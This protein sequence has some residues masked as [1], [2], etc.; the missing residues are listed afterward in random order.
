MADFLGGELSYRVIG[1][2]I[3]SPAITGSIVE[4]VIECAT[5]ALDPA[6]ATEQQSLPSFFIVGPPRT[7]S[8]WLYEI[9]ST[10]TRL[11]GPSKETRFFDVHFHRGLE[12]YLAHYQD[13]HADRQMGEVAPTYFAS[14]AARERISDLAPNA[15]IVCV[16][17]NPVERVLSLYRLKLAYGH[18]RW[19]LE[20]A[21]E[22][23]PELLESSQYSGNLRLWQRSF[24]AHNVWPGIYDDLRANPQAFVDSLADFIGISRF[25]L[26]R[27][28]QVPVHDSEGMTYPRSYY[29][30]RL[31]LYMAD[32]FKARRLDKFVVA[33]KRSP[34]RHFIL[35]GGKPFRQ[36]K[37][38]L[39][40]RL[41]ERLRPEVEALEA[42]LQ[43]D[44]SAWR[45]PK[46]VNVDC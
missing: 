7:G 45:N 9:L 18:I 34:V 26:A 38:Q 28:H 41:Y 27:S 21:I 6:V 2:E 23:D 16:F 22:R 20:Q 17:R 12:W 11:P 8:T 37:P 42:M 19:P 1:A 14:A 33:L 3:A 24:G 35:G 25:Q 39:L 10:C 31:A 32:W 29:R 30:T 5:P 36:P 44:L 4:P 13:S 43:R 40:R 15:K 46:A